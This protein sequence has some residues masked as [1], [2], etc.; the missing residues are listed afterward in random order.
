V[1]VAAMFPTLARLHVG[2][3]EGLRRAYTTVMPLMALLGLPV[4]AGLII[5]ADQ[6]IAVLYGSDYAASA[7]VLR[8]LAVAVFLI[9]VDTANTMLLYS[10]DDLG[11]VLR[12]SLLTTLANVLL[13][14]ILIPRY[15][16]NGAAV[17]AILSSALSLLI[18][19]PAVL[20]YLRGGTGNKKQGPHEGETPSTQRGTGGERPASLC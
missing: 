10:G 1:I 15:S 11:M 16:Y 9:F 5:F 12:L 2:S 8:L 6:I 3:R 7:N 19:T 20:R 13:N 4:M 17:A 18:F 14:L